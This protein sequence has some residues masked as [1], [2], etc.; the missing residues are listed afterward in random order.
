[1]RHRLDVHAA[2][3]RDDERHPAGAAIDQQ[4]AV[5]LAGDVGAVFD[6]EPVDL[7]A[8]RP[9]LLG[10]QRVPEHFA[11]IGDHILDRPR[12]PH[13]A[14]GVGSEFLELALAAPAG[15]DLALHHIE[16]TRQLLCRRLGLVGAKRSP[17]PWP[18][19]GHRLRAGPW[20]GVRGC[21]CLPTAS[22][23]ERSHIRRGRSRRSGNPV[24]GV[25][26]GTEI[27]ASLQGTLWEPDDSRMTYASFGAIFLQASTRPFTAATDLSKAFCSLEVSEISTTFS[28]PSAPSITGTPT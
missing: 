23:R 26:V 28:T 21:S 6:I 24:C 20:P 11:G 9:G 16:R 13:A 27:P 2:F 14:L 15:M 22:F 5:E 8:V 4:R 1:M 10:H 18:P 25:W 12:E 3:G 19:A 17:R 7:L